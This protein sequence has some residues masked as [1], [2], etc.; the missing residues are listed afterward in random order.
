MSGRENG[1]EDSLVLID[2][3]DHRLRSFNDDGNRNGRKYVIDIG[4]K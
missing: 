3:I 2:E 4:K 1:E